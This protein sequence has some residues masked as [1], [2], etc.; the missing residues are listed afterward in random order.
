MRASRYVSVDAVPVT[1][2]PVKVAPVDAASI[3]PD[4]SRLT[5]GT[6]NVYRVSGVHPLH[7]VRHPTPQAIAVPAYSGILR[8]PG[9]P[10]GADEDREV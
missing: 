10:E 1:A 6:D 7:M 8:R 5:G 3:A 9:F 2:K 4:S